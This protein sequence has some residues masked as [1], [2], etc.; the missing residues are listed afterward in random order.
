MDEPIPTC[1][2]GDHP[3]LPPSAPPGALHRA[4]QLF[5]AMG[6]APRLRL[7]ELLKDRELCVTEIVALIGEK[8]STVSQRLVL[9]HREGLLARRREGNHLHYSLA[10]RHVADLVANALAH[11]TELGD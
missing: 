2:S 8:F 6:D 3:A 11:A 1:A 10:D 5:R 4:A 9:L 7:L